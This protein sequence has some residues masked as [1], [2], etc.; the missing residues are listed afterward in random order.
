MLMKCKSPWFPLVND[1]LRPK[2]FPL[3]VYK[4]FA[5]DMKQKYVQVMVVLA[6]ISLFGLLAI[7][8]FWFKVAFNEQERQ[9]NEK[10]NIALRAVA[11]GLLLQSKDS[12]TAIRPIIQRATNDF[13]VPFNSSASYH[14]VDSLVRVQLA[15]YQIK[16]G[17]QLTLYQAKNNKVL[18]GNYTVNDTLHPP[19][20]ACRKECGLHRPQSS[21][22]PYKL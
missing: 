15:I 17:Y 8:L 14:S 18:L 7:Q 5:I 3:E 6:A 4:E 12:T 22:N 9:F 21:N 11:H 20:R 13:Y 1:Y 2:E 19:A 16:T 10:V